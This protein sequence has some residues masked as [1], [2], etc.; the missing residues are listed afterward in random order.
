MSTIAKYVVVDKEGNEGDWEFDTL[1]EAINAADDYE[2]VI[3]RYYEYTYS[4][5]VRNY[6]DPI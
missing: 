3:V 4:E 1:H 5:T 6:G 2:S